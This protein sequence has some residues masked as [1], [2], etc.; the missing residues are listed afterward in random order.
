MTHYFYLLVC[1]IT[2]EQGSALKGVVYH[3]L[4]INPLLTE[5]AAI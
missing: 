4:L 2:S 3:T 1:E 5:R